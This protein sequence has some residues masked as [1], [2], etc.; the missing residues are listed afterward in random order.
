MARWQ[1]IYRFVLHC[2][3]QSSAGFVQC[4]YCTDCRSVTWAPGFSVLGGKFVLWLGGTLGLGLLRKAPQP[5][6]SLLR[7][8]LP[9]SSMP[10]AQLLTENLRGPVQL[11]QTI[12]QQ[13]PDSSPCST[14]HS[15]FLGSISEDRVAGTTK[16]QL[17]K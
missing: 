8:I 3:R 6:Q 12:P 4:T 14:R 15:R 13:A 1:S 7:T 2:W 9:L 5:V 11:W 16:L 17:T 10:L